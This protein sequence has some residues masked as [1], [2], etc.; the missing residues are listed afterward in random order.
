[1]NSIRVTCKNF[2]ISKAN[3]DKFMDLYYQD[4]AIELHEMLDD[5][6]WD[7]TRTRRTGITNLDKYNNYGI[8]DEE[9]IFFKKLAPFVDPGAE[10][11]FEIVYDKTY[12]EKWEFNGTLNVFDGN[13]EI[14]WTLK[15]NINY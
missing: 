7:V 11:V 6:G 5:L 12:Y 15:Q 1:M 10:F 4:S 8:S 2:K 14:I 3:V 13:P 9:Y